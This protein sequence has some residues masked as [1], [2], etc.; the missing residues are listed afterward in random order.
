MRELPSTNGAIEER[1]EFQRNPY[2]G[3]RA[4]FA[5][6]P[7]DLGRSPRTEPSRRTLSEG[8][9]TRFGIG[10][11]VVRSL[12]TIEVPFEGAPASG[13]SDKGEGLEE[14][15]HRMVSRNH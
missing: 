7:C 9:M 13:P 2:V 14:A 4:C 10:M 3:R 12:D 6:S 15:M 5:Y 1:T 11:Q 8:R